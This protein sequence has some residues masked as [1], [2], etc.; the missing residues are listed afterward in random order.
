MPKY[1]EKV[2]CRKNDWLTTISFTNGVEISLVNGLIGRVANNPDISTFDGKQFT[3]DFVPDLIS[4]IIFPGVRC[5]YRHINAPNKERLILRKDKYSVGNMFEYAYAITGWIAQGSQW[6]NV[7]YIEDYVHPSLKN[8]L[9]YV[10]ATR[11]V[12][13]LIYAK[14]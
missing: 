10:G 5:N 13:N 12:K 6:N 2:V 11:A 3:I 4:N 9:N 7:L 8:Q 14:I 1:G